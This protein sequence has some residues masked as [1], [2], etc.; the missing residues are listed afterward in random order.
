M[1]RLSKVLPSRAGLIL[2]TAVMSMLLL[3][4]TAFAGGFSGP[5]GAHHHVAGGEGS[6]DLAIFL[7]IIAVAVVSMLILSRPDTGRM[8]GRHAAK[9]VQ[10]DPAG[11]GS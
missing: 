10:R 1:R 6:L 8:S 2:G 5:R 3:P 7:G 9:S 4:V 11:A